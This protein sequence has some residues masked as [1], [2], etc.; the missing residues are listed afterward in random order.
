[1]SALA[2]PPLPSPLSVRAH[3]AFR[4]NR[5]FFCTKTCGR[6]HLK[7]PPCLHWTNSPLTADVFHGWPLQEALN[8]HRRIRTSGPYKVFCWFT[9][10]NVSSLCNKFFTFDVGD[11]AQ[12][13][14]PASFNPLLYMLIFFIVTLKQK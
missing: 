10:M 7:K 8:A 6:P 13:F 12:G 11:G 9:F 5:E 4:K 1:M 14:R 3:H 2:Q